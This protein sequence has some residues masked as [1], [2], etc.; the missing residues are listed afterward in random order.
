MEMTKEKIK[1]LKDLFDEYVNLDRQSKQLTADLKDALSD[2]VSTDFAH[3][4][5]HDQ[6]TAKKELIRYMNS[7]KE[8]SDGAEP[9]EIVVKVRQEHLP[10]KDNS[11]GYIQELYRRKIDDLELKEELKDKRDTVIQN[12]RMILDTSTDITK[13]IFNE[14][15]KMRKGKV[16]IVNEVAGF[17]VSLTDLIFS[18]EQK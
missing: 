4:E 14:W 18:K 3:I 11:W 6:K 1:E 13:A 16:S 15:L 9:V 5:P 17:V 10:V 12:A 2:F 7:K 8:Y